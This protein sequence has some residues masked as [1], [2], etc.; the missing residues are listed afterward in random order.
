MNFVKRAISLT[1]NLTTGPSAGKSVQVSGLRTSVIITKGGEN[2]MPHA[3][4][5]VCGLSLSLMN[6]I[7]ILGKPLYGA[8]PNTVIIQAGDAGTSNLPTVFVGNIDIAWADMDSAPETALMLDCY[9]T[10]EAA[11][12]PV[13]PTSYQGAVD[14]V[15]VMTDFAAR[16]NWTVENGLTSSATIPNPYWPGTLLQQVRKAAE[17]FGIK[18]DVYGNILA[19]WPIGGSRRGTIPLVSPQTGMIGYPTYTQDGMI[20]SSIYN[21]AIRPNG[22]IKVQSEIQPA[23]GEWT[24]FALTHELESE[25]PSGAWRSMMRCQNVEFAPA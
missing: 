13:P 14:V 3:Q 8:N 2:G 9:T 4:V 19:L 25:T 18:A 12:R 10:M 22:R 11:M 7:T 5:R 20:V 23:C 6:Q 1:F 16:G 17:A 15:T 21:P 24:V